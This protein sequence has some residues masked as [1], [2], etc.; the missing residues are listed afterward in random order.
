MRKDEVVLC[1]FAGSPEA[2]REAAEL[3]EV[4]FDRFVIEHNRFIGQRDGLTRARAPYTATAATAL[5]VALARDLRAC[6]EIVESACGF[7]MG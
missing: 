7:R 1:L 2:V 4:P 5:K 3:A 6:Q